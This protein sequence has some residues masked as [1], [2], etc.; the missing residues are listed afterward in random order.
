MRLKQITPFIPC[1]S[2]AKQIGFYA[3]VLGFKVGFQSEFYAFLQRDDVAVRL[4]QVDADVDLTSPDR[5]VSFYIDVDAIDELYA[6]LKDALDR[7]N[8]SRVRA[9]FDQQYGQRELHI[10]DEDCTLVFFGQ[11]IS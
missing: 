7:L 6:D 3:G 1:T 9:P 4:V 2:L 11:A 10:F 5:Q 8:P